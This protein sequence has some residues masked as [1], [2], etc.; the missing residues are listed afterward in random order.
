MGSLSKGLICLASFAVLCACAG[1]ARVPDAQPS[2]AAGSVEST[3][4]LIWRAGLLQVRDTGRANE[5]LLVGLA[6]ENAQR[7]KMSVRAAGFVR[8]GSMP[9]SLTAA[10]DDADASVRAEAILTA[11]LWGATDLVP[12]IMELLE[13]PDT[14][15]RSAIAVALGML[16]NSEASAPLAK[17]LTDESKDVR[18]AAC[19]AAARLTGVDVLVDPMLE[20]VKDPD[21]D[22]SA[23]ALYALSRLSGRLEALDFAAR[24]KIREE[25]VRLSESRNPGILILVAEGLY[26]PIAGQQADTL[27]AM[28]RS[29]HPEV[30]L[31]I[32]RSTSIP[33]APAFVFHEV[34]IKH[35][36]E[37]VVQ[38]TILGLGR[39]RGDS[40]SAVL[41]DFILKDTRD[42]LRAEAIR[43]LSRADPALLMQ[44]ANGLSK[45]PRPVLRAATAESLYGNESP[46]AAEYARRL[47]EDDEPWVRVHAIPA[48]AAVDEPLTSVFRD[49]P[50]L[51][52]AEAR[53]RMA[54][55]AGYRLSMTSRSEADHADSIKLLARIWKQASSKPSPETQLAVIQ[56]AAES[57]REDGAVL[58]RKALKAAD[59]G[60]RQRARALLRSHFEEDGVPEPVKARSMSYYEEIAAWAEQPRAAVVTVARQGFVPG[61]FTIALDTENAPLTSW[62]FSRLANE[63]FY[64]NRRVA[65]YLPALRLHSGR[66][67]DDRYPSTSW[68]EEPAF[69]LFGPGT[70]AGAGDQGVLMGEWVVTLGARPNYLGRYMPFGRVVQNLA[71]VVGN[72][73]PVDRVVQVRAYEGNGRETLP[74]LQ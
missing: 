32:L 39:M 24:F 45:D 12:A 46:E 56:A 73:L 33:G 6:S 70:V 50:E 25:L 62:H 34:L 60:V 1:T 15:V 23:A 20:M 40:V 67:S 31:A 17:L 8:D 2:S 14:S 37:R 35:K 58:V 57:G 49:F 48:M 10:L 68:P 72:I 65:P 19:Y 26:S 9:G 4:D 54:L 47:F 71:G 43:S 63:R 52:L 51:P 29:D 16:A 13:D 59:P 28:M 66:G 38:G 69:S 30:L 27:H 44:I 7:R 61:R 18:L 22:I 42:W 36:D 74:P 5:A 3:P 41:L 53:M 21:T 55:A 64:D 11:G